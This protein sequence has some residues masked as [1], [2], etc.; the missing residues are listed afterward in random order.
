MRC[1]RCDNEA[2]IQIHIIENGEDPQTINLCETCAQNMMF[3]NFSNED[4]EEYQYFQDHLKK[5]VGVF[6]NEPQTRTE[7]PDDQK[8][9]SFCG[10]SFSDITKTGR[11]GC[12]HC[13]TEF[14]E[15]A[16]ESLRM[17]QG[18]TAHTGDVPEDFGEIKQIQDEIQRK[19]EK[20][21][22]LILL[23]DYETAAILRDEVKE[24]CNA[25]ERGTQ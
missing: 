3:Q 17:T 2:T 24:L 11:F 25:L 1:D 12:D 5:L 19:K 8:K 14:Y 21:Q 13:Y 18:A 15:Q 20:M 16:K 22:E 23:E 4:N 7:S 6:F 10:S 9:C